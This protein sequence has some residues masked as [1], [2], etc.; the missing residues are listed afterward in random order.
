MENGK[1][2]WR[3]CNLFSTEESFQHDEKVTLKEN[4]RTISDKKRVANVFTLQTLTNPYRH[5]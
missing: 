3:A 1:T 4:K 2:F 5:V